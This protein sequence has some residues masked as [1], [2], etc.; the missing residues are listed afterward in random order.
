MKKIII[1]TIIYIIL[2]ITFLI[3]GI[4]GYINKPLDIPDKE[5]LNITYYRYYPKTGNYDEIKLL[6]KELQYEGESFDLQNC[7]NYTY[8]EETGILKLDCRKAFRIVGYT[9]DALVIN[10]NR[11]NQY[12]YKEKEKS[13][14]GEFQRKYKMTLETYK[15]EGEILLKEKE[16]D[17]EN[18]IDLFKSKETSYVYL[19]G[20][21]CKNECTLFNKEFLNFSDKNLYYLNTTE[22][23]EKE[24]EELKELEDFPLESLN[25]DYPQVLIIK[26]KKIEVIKIEG[27]G[28]DYSM[29][30][31]Y[32][33][34][35]EENENE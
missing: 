6:E 26:D 22:L 28:F 27:K 33:N 17:I 14:N 2:I 16:M 31:N 10:I 35:L 12:F 24:K 23:N 25:K 5:I 4:I 29:Y 3:L 7:K 13:Y 18:L 9:E 32:S 20:D 1:R 30:N 21:N 34:N 11:E 19:K 15:K 8:T